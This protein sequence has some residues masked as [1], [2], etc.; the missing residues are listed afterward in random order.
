MRDC[1]ARSSLGLR[2]HR[3]PD[4]PTLRLGTLSCLQL[5]LFVLLDQR[6]AID[7]RSPSIQPFD[8]T[9]TPLEPRT[10][11]QPE[12]PKKL[13]K[14]DYVFTPSIP[15]VNKKYAFVSTRIFSRVQPVHRPVTETSAPHASDFSDSLHY[16]GFWKD[17]LAGRIR[18]VTSVIFRFCEFLAKRLLN[19]D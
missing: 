1:A 4:K 18:T 7:P 3:Q 10:P 17:L 11:H 9:V 16:A 14:N 15:A 2:A 19:K 6:F 8:R 12:K 13:S 5:V